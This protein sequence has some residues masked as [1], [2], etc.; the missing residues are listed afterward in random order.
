MH[1]NLLSTPS[2]EALDDFA[3]ALRPRLTGTLHR[4]AMTRALY[5]TDASLFQIQPLA[6]L[7]PRHVDDV[8]AALEAAATYRLP[9]LPR[10]GGTS[11]AGQ[12][13]G[14]AL[15]I[16]ST[17][18]LDGILEINAEER[19]VRVEPGVVLDDLNAALAPH[20]LMV[21]PDP[22][23]SNR[24]TLGG[25]VGNNATGTH[26]ILYGNMIEHVREIRALLAG[27]IATTFGPLDADA[28][29][30]SRLRPGPEGKLYRGL[31]RLLREEADVIRRDTP[32]HWRRNSGYRLEY[33]LD[34]VHT[35]AGEVRTEARNV[36]RL[37]CGSEGTLAVTTEVTLAVVP[38]P[39]QTALGVVHFR[40]RGAALRAVTTILETSPAAIELFD[41]VAIEQ[42][43][44]APGYA[45]RLGFLQGNPGAVLITEY[46]GDTDAALADRL[47]TLD[48][49]LKNAGQGYAVVRVTRPEAIRDVWTVRREGLGLL[50]SV[51]GDYKPVAFVEC[52]L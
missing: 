50:M 19:W 17:C 38:R 10:G 21:G 6:V 35:F 14:A 8:Q 41:G 20:G 33:L 42:T 12:A 51:K 44:Q 34:R 4:D 29:N 18:H 45:H 16:D 22:A 48:T 13:V 52:D 7:V 26:S 36:A 2:A 49:A 3:E 43:R 30:A 5:A 47:D 46:Y 37:L 9:V 25:M 28:W 23:P 15:V 27:G 31:D 32:T 24:A 39:A 40:T 1:P 11:L